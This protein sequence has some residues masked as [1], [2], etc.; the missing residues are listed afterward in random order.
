V[1]SDSKTVVVAGAQ[2]VIGRAAAERFHELGW[3]V[4]GLARRPPLDDLPVTQ[5]S[6]DLLD[7]ADTAAKLR[8]LGRATH[9]V[10]AAYVERASA[11]EA[12][13]PNV[14]MLRNTLDALEAIS[15]NLEHVTLY[16]GG[17]AYGA[18]LGP[19]KTP[20][21]ED[22]PRHMPPN[23]YYDQ[24]DLLRAR[25][26]GKNWHW[27]ALRPEAVCGYALG[28]PMNL[29]MVIAV[30]ATICKELGLPLRFPGTGGAN[31]ALY[32]VTSADVLA[33]ATAWAA[34]S[35]AARNEIFNITN[36]DYFRWR[37]LWPAIARAFA[38]PLGDPLHIPLVEYMADKAPLWERIVAREGLRPI[39][40]EQLASWGFGDAIF[41]M[42]FDNITSTVKARRA[43]FP[44][45]IDTEEMFTEFFA[46]LRR[47]RVIPPVT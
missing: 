23:F 15:P 46:D 27:T 4:V 41:G 16:Q 26:R 2:G 38:I 33:R 18:H 36:G 10:F 7:P 47:R 30:Y 40:Y 43:G 29:A 35:P 20:A 22:D 21:R 44:D 19:F 34:T 13:A 45:C 8:G 12:V 28:N 6:V 25:Q 5:L 14:A 32:Q 31:D 3:D 9:L 24:E 42:E 17:K 39:P 37:Y 1:T 11:R